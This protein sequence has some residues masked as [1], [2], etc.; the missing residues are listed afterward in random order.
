MIMLVKK[1]I[2]IAVT[3][4]SLISQI[5]A[6]D[7]KKHQVLIIKNSSESRKS[8]ICSPTSCCNRSIG[9]HT[10]RIILIFN[11]GSQQ[12]MRLSGKNYIDR[13]SNTKVITLRN[14]ILRKASIVEPNN[15]VN[16][17]AQELARINSLINQDAPHIVLEIK[18][19][20]DKR[21]NI[22]IYQQQ[23]NPI[24]NKDF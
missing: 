12:K 1:N 5:E 2:I 6:A 3:W 9:E 15:I 11:D 13:V 22:A 18:K 19:T 20:S 10:Y 16:L 14:R 21:P 17:N 23:M 4:L 8:K 24:I 7:L